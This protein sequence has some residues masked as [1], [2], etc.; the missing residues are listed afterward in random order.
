MAETIEMLIGMWSRFS[1]GSVQ[2]SDF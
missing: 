2:F 1:P